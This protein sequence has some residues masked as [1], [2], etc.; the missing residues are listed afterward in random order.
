MTTLTAVS[1]PSLRH[2]V[3]DAGSRF[4][5]VD[6]G[7]ELVENGVEPLRVIHHQPVAHP[8]HRSAG[9]LG[10]DVVQV[11]RAVVGGGHVHHQLGAV[12]GAKRGSRG[13]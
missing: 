8:G 7:Q 9:Q 2:P 10:S 11:R 1:H 12:E 5:G 4:A 3:R 6:L 13:A